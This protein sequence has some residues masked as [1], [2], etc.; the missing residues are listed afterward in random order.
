MRAQVESICTVDSPDPAVHLTAV[1]H[2]A[3][4]LC[5]EVCLEPPCLVQEGANRGCGASA[6]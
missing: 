4:S 6:S 1:L 3:S 2:Y 5:T